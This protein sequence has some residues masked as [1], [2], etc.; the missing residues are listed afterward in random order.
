MCLRNK[1]FCSD[2]ITFEGFSNGSSSIQKQTDGRLFLSQDQNNVPYFI[3]QIDLCQLRPSG[4]TGKFQ[5]VDTNSDV[6]ILLFIYSSNSLIHER[7]SPNLLARISV[8]C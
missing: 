4:P 7:V 3:L 6:V 8:F 2:S 5:C 1:S